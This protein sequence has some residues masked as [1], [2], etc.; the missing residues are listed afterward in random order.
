M[1]PH[2][3]NFD[4]AEFLPLQALVPEFPWD[5]YKEEEEFTLLHEIVCHISGRDLD[6]AVQTHPAD[7]NRL[8]LR[9][10]SPLM[11]AIHH[12][13]IV[14]IRT[15]LR[16]GADPNTCNGKALC[17]TLSTYS[18]KVLVIVELL[19]GS[20]ATI[21]GSA[22]DD[23][24]A[25][26]IQ[27]SPLR[28][29]YPDFLAIDKILIEHGIDVNHQCHRAQEQTLLMKLCE[30]GWLSSQDMTPIGRIEQLIGLGADLELRD[31]TERTALHF[32]IESNYSKATKFLVHA[33]AC[34]DV[35]TNMGNTVAHLAVIFSMSIG[36]VK[37]ISEI[38]LGRLDLGLKNEDGHTA[39][40]LLRKR[41]GLKW[42][43][44]YEE[45]CQ[46]T[47]YYFHSGRFSHPGTEYQT[48]L[49]L[50]ALLHHIQDSQGIPKDQQYPPLV[51][52]LSDDKDENPVPGAWPL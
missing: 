15:L 39:Y 49:A 8:D 52:Y 51:E 11:I 50:E 35:K 48:I 4:T 13:D 23:V 37:A 21:Y 16:R 3:E 41:N 46:R 24:A 44:H 31:S 9:G 2:G 28:T 27:Y 7:I 47:D 40:D 33:G 26:W 38:D 30:Y 42:E 19:L 20:G 43:K 14:A 29:Y 45:L 17:A 1:F 22:R 5:E 34:L 36:F 32:A 12:Q 10:R 6:N 25:E 18:N